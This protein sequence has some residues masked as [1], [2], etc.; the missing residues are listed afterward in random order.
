MKILTC[1]QQK[2]ADAYTIANEP[3]SSIELMERAAAAMTRIICSRWDTSHRMIVIAG[4]GNNGGDAL[5]IARLLAD[6][7]YSVNVIFFNVTGKIS[8]ECLANVRRL[9]ETAIESYTEVT[10]ELTI[11]AIKPTDVIIGLCRC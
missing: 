5:A 11:P 2:E 7:G 6:K 9:D 10:K 1:A 8:E 3:I 4:A